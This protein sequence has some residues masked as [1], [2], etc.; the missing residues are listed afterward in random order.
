[1]Q[2][3]LGR[4]AVRSSDLAAG[5]GYYTAVRDAAAGRGPSRLL[6]DALAARSMTLLNMGRLA[7][8]AEDAR[9]ALALARELGYPAGEAEA[10]SETRPSPL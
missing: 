8:G 7:E 10:L 5:L 2:F 9:R 4:A 6:A 3:W 1:M